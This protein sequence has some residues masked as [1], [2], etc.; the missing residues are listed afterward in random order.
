MTTVSIEVDGRRYDVTANTSVA[1]ALM[2]LPTQ[3]PTAHDGSPFCG[4]GSCHA[5]LLTVDGVRGVR[6]CITP[7]RDDMTIERTE[8]AT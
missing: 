5:C 3:V 2:D 6:A 1:A 7:V 8:A 4:M